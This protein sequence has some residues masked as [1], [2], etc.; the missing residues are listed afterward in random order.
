MI[1]FFIIILFVS[2]ILFINL[3]KYELQNFIL[4][5]PIK[6]NDYLSKILIQE[7][8]SILN[9]NISKNISISEFNVETIDHLK[10]NGLFMKNPFTQNLIIY[11]HGNAGN[12]YDCFYIMQKLG[13]YSSIILFDYRGFGKNLGQPTEDGLYIDILTVW[14]FIINYLKINP[15]HVTLYGES[16][17]T[18]MVTWLGAYLCEINQLPCSIIIHSGFSNLKDLAIEHFGWLFAKLTTYQFHNCKNINKIGSKIP[19][20]VAHSPNDELINYIHKDKIISSNN[21]QNI[22]FFKLEGKHFFPKNFENE[23]FINIIRTYLYEC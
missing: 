6:I 15:N 1:I 10:I 17:G 9:K 8:L 12:L 13:K 11:S 7:N 18:A 4:F 21:E 3:S 5:H 20:L 2:F 14:N 16:L 22:Q 19:I 23:K